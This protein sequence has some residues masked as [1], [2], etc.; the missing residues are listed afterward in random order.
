M[1]IY[2][3]RIRVISAVSSAKLVDTQLCEMLRARC[4]GRASCV[5]FLLYEYVPVPVGAL[6]REVGTGRIIYV[7]QYQ[8]PWYCVSH[9][10]FWAP[11]PS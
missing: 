11:A 7:P 6:V 1:R 4:I 9:F 2:L 5:P 10:E 8:V 3:V